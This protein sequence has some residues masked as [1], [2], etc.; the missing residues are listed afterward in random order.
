MKPPKYP[1]FYL[2]LSHFSLFGTLHSD[3][4][5]VHGIKSWDSGSQPQP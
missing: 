5:F 1:P 2:P 3:F 4:D